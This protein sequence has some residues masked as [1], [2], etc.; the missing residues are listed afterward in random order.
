MDDMSAHRLFTI[1]C[2]FAH[3]GAWAGVEALMEAAFTELRSAGRQDLID[4]HAYELHMVL[5][6]RRDDIPLAMHR[7][8]I[9]HSAWSE[10][11]TFLW[12]APIASFTGWWI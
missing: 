4:A 2:R 9:L 8:P 7:S 12:I 3:S 10:H 1:D 11:A 6:R 5:K